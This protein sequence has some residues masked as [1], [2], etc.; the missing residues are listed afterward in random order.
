MQRIQI[1][2][3]VLEVVLLDQA[4]GL[5][6]ALDLVPDGVVGAH[7]F[8]GCVPEPE[9]LLWNGDVK[10]TGEVADG[11]AGGV[12]QVIAPYPF[13]DDLHRIA[14]MFGDLIDEGMAAGVAVPAL[15]WLMQGPA[16]AFLDHVFSPAARAAGNN[17]VAWR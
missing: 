12:A 8:L 14:G 4:C 1:H 17:W 11:L 10:A 13:H 2:L 16:P 9:C 7:R 15:A 5:N 3:P 6:A